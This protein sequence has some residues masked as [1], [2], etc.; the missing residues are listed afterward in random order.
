MY[1]ITPTLLANA[2]FHF[3]LDPRQSDSP[4]YNTSGRATTMFCC[5]H[6]N[7]FNT[8]TSII[9]EKTW[10]FAKQEH[11]TFQF[12]LKREHENTGRLQE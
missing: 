4:Q 9:R 3:V 2:L 11:N 1:C 7:S 10:N 5:T 6:G 12:H 8:C